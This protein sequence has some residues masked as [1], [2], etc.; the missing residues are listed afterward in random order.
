MVL[1]PLR[2]AP[3]GS[4]EAKTI[5]VGGC[6]SHQ[7]IKTSVNGPSEAGFVAVLLPSGESAIYVTECESASDGFLASQA[8]ATYD[9]PVL[10]PRL[11]HVHFR[12][13]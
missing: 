4:F 3:I 7:P 11:Y 8:V 10:E 13:R 2:T 5:A 9:K 6:V 12:R 1:V